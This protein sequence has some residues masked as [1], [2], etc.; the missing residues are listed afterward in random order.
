LEG[1]LEQK[2]DFL[3][4][5]G[6]LIW[7]HSVK[8]PNSLSEILSDL[9][10]S[11]VYLT[12]T[13]AS[14]ILELDNKCYGGMGM[15]DWVLTDLVLPFGILG[16]KKGDEFIAEYAGLWL[17]DKKEANLVIHTLAVHPNYRKKGIGKTLQWIWL[18]LMN[19]YLNELGVKQVEVQIYYQKS[20]PSVNIHG[21]YVEEVK[22]AIGRDEETVLGS[23]KL[24]KEKLVEVA[25]TY[26]WLD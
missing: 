12:P 25:K 15:P 22:K 19:K 11:S 21:K 1:L 10:I 7:V 2:V 14:K 18:T 6:E 5:F 20:N 26:G 16:V 9:N 24:T 23:F 13:L 3:K 17:L 8:T 4:G